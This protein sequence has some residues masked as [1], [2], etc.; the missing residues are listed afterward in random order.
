MQKPHNP[1]G[2]YI[3]YGV[4][5]T[6]FSVMNN[7]GN[8]MKPLF[9]R[10]EKLGSHWTTKYVTNGTAESNNSLLWPNATKLLIHKRYAHNIPESYD[11]LFVVGGRHSCL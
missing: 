4:R 7:A 3:I 6:G 9:W 8:R 2:Q 1:P 11:S 10:E 5:P